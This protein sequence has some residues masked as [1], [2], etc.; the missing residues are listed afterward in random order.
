MTSQ[1]PKLLLLNPPGRR[2]YLRDYFCSKVSQADYINHP[3][4]LLCL[5]GLLHETFELSVVDAIVEKLAPDTCIAKV[6]E[7]RPEV[8][9]GLIGAASLAEDVPFY[10]NLVSETG[11]RLI[12]IGDALL[13]QRARRLQSMPFVEAFLHDFS[14]DDVRT[15]L[16]RGA[17]QTLRNM[18]VRKNGAVWAAPIKRPKHETWPLALPRHELFL[19]KPYR[20]PFVRS[21]RFATVLTE[22]GCPYRCTF[23]IMSTLGWKIRPVENVLA[24]LARLKALGVRELFFLDQTFGLDKSRALR[25]LAHMP[26]GEDGFG[27][28]CFSR[29]DV[30]D[31]ELL[32]AMKRG[33]CHTV[34]LGLESG[35]DEILNSIRKEMDKAQIQRGFA[36]CREWGIRT[37]ATVIL[38]LPEE[39]QGTF[40]ETLEFLKQVDPDF[41]SFNVAV[42]RVGTPFRRTALRLGLA[43]PE[44]ETMDQS[45]TPVCLPSLT[46][47]REDIRALKRRAIREFYLNPGYLRKRLAR[48][49]LPRKEGWAELRIQ[50]RQGVS[51]LRNYLLS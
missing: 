17:Q 43:P 4:D 23:C 16:E 46:L 10:R 30:L 3:I 51:L 29:A 15:Y 9:I 8:V 14:T 48:L 5:S 27:W 20:Y 50:L 34:I 28:V 1:K 44:L 41:A 37:V 33:G 24:E 21:T 18:T 40:T 47:T 35:N 25:L 39:T 42:P 32:R 6:R 49:G 31:A 12:L 2:V 26:A 45:G 19:N 7:R 11:T 22:Y 38:G 36:L 13:E